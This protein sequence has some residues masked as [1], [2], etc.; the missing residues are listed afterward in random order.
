MYDKYQQNL[1]QSIKSQS[2]YAIL[3]TTLILLFPLVINSVKVLGNLI[4]LIIAIVGIYISFKW[5]KNPFKIR[6]L[7]LFS[8]IT[9]GYFLV[10]LFS[11]LYADGLNAEFH[12]LGRKV[13]FLLAPWIALAVLNINLPLNKLLM[14][15]KIGLIIIGLIAIVQFYFQLGDGDRGGMMNSNVFA[16]ITVSMLFLSIVRWF[17]ETPKMRLFTLFSASA[18]LTAIVLAASRG[19]WLSFILLSL[20]FIVLIYKPFLKHHLGRKIFL[21]I[22]MVSFFGFISS[23]PGVKNRIYEATEDVKNWY[24]GSNSA[25]SNDLRLQIWDA[26]IRAYKDSP[27]FGYGYRNANKVIS[28]Y[29]TANAELI[30]SKTHL[31][32]EY[33]TNL[34]SAGVIGLIA[35]II[36]L[37]KPLAVF[38]H[39]IKRQESF[40]Y[41]LMGVLLCSGYITYGFTHIA[42]GEE[43]MNAFYVLF[44]SFLLPKIVANN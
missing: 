41:A 29:T 19:S 14:N 36:L 11:I 43:H 10:M 5:H 35:L 24:S 25:S 7:K 23:E 17:D 26:S 37:F 8:F 6:E 3:I 28:Q 32:N 9:F 12:H 38:L 44:M 27:W 13:H 42:L 18:G 39:S 40:Y 15:I 4:L 31:H 20:V 22:F 34:L 16:D 30:A 2:S 21:F 1:T 33:L